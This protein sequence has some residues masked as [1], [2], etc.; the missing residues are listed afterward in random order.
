MTT[1]ETITKLKAELSTVQTA[2]KTII[3]NGQAFRKGSSSGFSVEFTKLPL[4]E[5]RESKLE[6]RI[7][8][9]ERS[10]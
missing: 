1:L 2:I 8:T 5:V 10:L 4:L 7:G 6:T 3:Q 9:L